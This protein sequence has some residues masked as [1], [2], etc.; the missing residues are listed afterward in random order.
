MRFS[1]GSSAS[2]SAQHR[3]TRVL[4]NSSTIQMNRSAFR[5]KLESCSSPEKQRFSKTQL[6]CLQKVTPAGLH[7][8]TT[9]SLFMSR[10][11]AENPQSIP[12]GVCWRACRLVFPNTELVPRLAVR[13]AT[14]S[15]I[16]V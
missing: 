2:N 5:R 4:S 8:I 1:S 13:M 14:D 12:S 7:E 11:L 10:N 9:L 3:L 16:R 6:P 15:P